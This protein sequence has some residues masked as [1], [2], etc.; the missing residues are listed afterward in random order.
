MQ[1]LLPA[2]TVLHF[3]GWHDNSANNRGNND[4]DNWIGYGQRTIDDMSHAW[5]TYY[6]LSDEE[7]KKAV[8][9]RKVSEQTNAKAKGKNL[10]VHP[11]DGVLAGGFESGIADFP[12]VF[13]AAVWI[14]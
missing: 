7:F 3:I 1:P 5:I 13:V 8:A 9:D 6:T 12:D 14:C 2:G 4:P 10:A 11:G